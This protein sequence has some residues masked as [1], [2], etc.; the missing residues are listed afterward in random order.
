MILSFRDKRT[1]LFAKCRAPQFT[2]AKSSLT[3]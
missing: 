2:P 3:N 1:E